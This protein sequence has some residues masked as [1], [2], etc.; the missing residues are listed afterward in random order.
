MYRTGFVGAPGIVNKIKNNQNCR[1]KFTNVASYLSSLIPRFKMY[2]VLHDEASKR[3]LK[4]Y[5]Q[6]RSCW[7]DLW[8]ALYEILCNL[9]NQ[10]NHFIVQWTSKTDIHFQ[11]VSIRPYHYFTLTF[12]FCKTL[13]AYG[14][15]SR[16]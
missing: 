8:S 6:Y 16:K 5:W 7:C 11:L 2:K 9:S 12:K 15:K 3:T 1:S 14:A 4:W 10:S 13:R